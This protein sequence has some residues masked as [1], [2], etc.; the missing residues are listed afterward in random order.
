MPKRSRTSFTLT[1][2]KRVRLAPGKRLSYRP[3]IPQSLKGYARLGGA[4][5]R[6]GG[7]SRQQEKKFFDTA[8]AFNFDATGEVPATGQLVLIPQGVTEQ[9]RVGRACVVKSL[10]L[11]IHAGFAP[12]AAATASTNCWIYVV[13]DTQ[14]NGAAAAITDVLTTNN[15]ATAL[16]N[17]DN[18]QRFKILKK[19]KMTFNPGAG[20]TTAYNNVNVD[21]EC[22]MKLNVPMDYSSTTGAITEI[23]SNNIFLLAGSDTTSDDTVTLDGNCRVRFTDS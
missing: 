8:L 18:S 23:R 10:Q 5:N 3:R 15:I 21:K 1:S 4:W 6:F 13:Q 20:V 17:L 22:Y 11:R 14:A 19:L 2:G 9:S 7:N 16:L 12:G